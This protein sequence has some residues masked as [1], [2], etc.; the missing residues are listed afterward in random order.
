MPGTVFISRQLPQEALDLARARAEVREN[1][2]D[3]RLGKAELAGRLADVEGL[4]CLL[5]DTVD[6]EVLAQAPRLRVVANVAVGYD[7]IDVPA[8]TRRKIVVT[9]TPG[10]LTETTADFTWA[11]LLATARRVAEADA[12]TRAGKF[13]EWGLMLLLGGDVHGKTLGIL[14]FG[15]IGRA[16]AQRARGFNMRLLYHDAVRDHAAE[17]DLGIEYAEKDALLRVADF[18]TL[19]VPLL[20]RAPMIPAGKHVGSLVR[21][22]DIAPTVLE[23]LGVGAPSSFEGETFI[24][25]AGELRARDVAAYSETYIP[26]LN[27]GW[28]ELRSLRRR[29]WKL[30][31]AP[32]SELYDVESDPLEERNRIDEERDIAQGLRA[33]LDE[34]LAGRGSVLPESVDEKTLASLRSLGY[35]GG[36]TAV[37]ADRSFSDLPDPKDE[38]AVYNEL[39]D[40]LQVSE[41]RPAD[42]ER[43]V[44]V[45]EKE[46]ENA[47]A[48]L[49]YGKFLLDLGRPRDAR[50]A[51]VRLVEVLPDGFDGHYGLGRALLGLGEIEAARAS[52]EKA[53]T[54]DPKSAEAYSRLSALEKSQGNLEA[55]ERWLREG[56]AMAPSRLLYQDLAGLLLSSGRGEEVSR[57][58]NEW[59]G[60]G[61]EAAAAYA[62]GQLLASQGNGEGALV[63]LERAVRLAPEDGNIEQALAN[64]LSGLGRF[65]EA[66]FHYEAILHR[67]PC[68][69]GA[70]TNLGA[71][72]ERQ[73]NVDE[74]IRS[75]ERA[76]GCDP[77]YANAYRNLGG[78]LAR[79]G[80][81][82][83]ALEVL[84]KAKRL[85]PGDQELDAAIAELESLKR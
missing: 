37:S 24:T 22:I 82:R 53:L 62:K 14:G 47:R 45:M 74:G 50:K 57:M 68:Y 3:R 85:A 2:E 58:A 61:A 21:T 20:I 42:L 51:F 75:Y 79:K 33:R 78:A 23:L 67:S 56:I 43:I 13:T 54:I 25:A 31:L 66:K 81:L 11:L 84:R 52:F 36:A 63:E 72:H 40:L 7:N 35:V 27:Y 26:R 5:T 12:Y 64:T 38:I 10:I 46:P 59:N 44:S 77:G 80:D 1:P 49:L 65:D 18:V 55:S 76:I 29:N 19:H 71:V 4:V 16:V 60:P 34:L 15:R 30:V 69:L 41:A 39:L 32:R 28:S 8:A 17:R 6:A 73:G 9:H 70:L 48:L 83:R